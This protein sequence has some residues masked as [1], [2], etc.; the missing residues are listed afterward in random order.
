MVLFVPKVGRSMHVLQTQDN[1]GY[2][3]PLFSLCVEIY[4]VFLYKKIRIYFSSI[5]ISH[6][7]QVCL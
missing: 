3:M 5:S 6:C 7:I 2:Q 4:K 1:G